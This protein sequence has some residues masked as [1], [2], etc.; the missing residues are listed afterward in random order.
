MEPNRTGADLPRIIQGG[1]GAGVSSW[2]LAGAVAATGQLGVVSGT[3]LEVIYARRLQRGDPGGHVRRA[4]AHFPDRAISDRIV[5]RYFVP[6]GKPPGEPFRGVPMYTLAPSAAVQELSVVSNFAE[7]WLAKELGSGG[8]VGIN[9]L[10]KIEMPLPASL[11][12]AMLAGVDFVIVGAGSPHDIPPMLSKLARGDDASLPIKVQYASSAD[13]YRIAFSPRALLGGLLAAVRRPQ[14]L[15]IVSSVG[16][17][18][19]LARGQAEPPDGFVIEGSTAGGHNAAPQGPMRLDA[20]GQPIYGP[21]DQVD[22]REFQALGLPFWLAGSHGSREA[23]RAARAAGATGIQVGTAFAFCRES[24]LASDLKSRILQQATDGT[25][26][27]FTDPRAS[28]TGFPFKVVKLSGTLSDAGLYSLRRRI[29]DLGYLRA[30]YCSAQG[31]VGYRC[32]SESEPMYVRKRGRAQN[33]EG[34]KCLCNA[35]VANIGLAQTR[36]GSDV[37]LPLVTAGDDVVNVARFLPRGGSSYGA[38]DV[39]AALLP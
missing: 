37:E 15:A 7:V 20:A 32:P 25:V 18:R 13:D 4:F 30:P 9:Y 16:L 8:L 28:P 23:F 29:C 11:Y 34:R 22:L 26:E 12:G 27:V 21:A 5:D 2:E 39:I 31:G 3:A 38:A 17:A 33:S 35:L 10:R 1:M 14:M 6:G 36:G 19:A 24:G